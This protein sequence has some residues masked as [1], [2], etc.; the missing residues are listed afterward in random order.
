MRLTTI[1]VYPPPFVNLFVHRQM[2]ELGHYRAINLWG[3]IGTRRIMK[4][5]FPECDI[6]DKTHDLAFSID[7]A[8]RVAAL[9]FNWVFLNFSWGFPP[10]V[11]AQDWELFRTAVR[12][13]HQVGVRVFGY[14]QA[15]NCVYQDSYVD[16]D[17]YA[18]DPNGN[19]IYCYIGR[20]YTSLLNPEWQAEVRGHIRTLVD[21]GADGIFFDNP[22][23]GGVGFDVAEMPL[24]VIGSYD[25]Y[26]QTAYS[27]QFD[28][29][30]I[31]LVLNTRNPAVQQYLRWRTSIAITVLTKWIEVAR[32]LN[33]SIL[34]GANNFDAIARNSYVT[35][36]MDL[37]GF[38][39]LQDVVTVEN[40][41]WPHL[42]D[43]DTVIAGAITI[44]ASQ[45]KSHG[46]PVTTKPYANGVGLE[47][48]WQPREFELAM[49]EAAAMK[50]PVVLQ[51]TGFRHIKQIT[52]LLH[53]RYK[54]QQ[55]TII[56]MNRWL[57]ANRQWLS[58]RRSA[59]PLAIYYPYDAIHW[60]WIDIAPIFFAACETLILNGF[61]L[62]IVG[63]EAW[64]GVHTLIVP[65]GKIDGLDKR[66]RQFV[67]DGGELITLGKSWS[68]V[69]QRVLWEN[70]RP[71][72]SRVPR[73]R[74]FRHRLNQGAAISW[75]AY[76]RYRWARWL[77][78]RLKIREAMVRSPM[79]IVPPQP[80]QKALVDAIGS[81]VRPR[82]VSEAPMLLT[83]WHEPDGTRQWHVV[84]Y[85]DEAQKVTLHLD[86]LTPTWV[87]TPGEEK[88]RQVVG[89]SLVLNVDVAKVIRTAY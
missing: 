82:L 61:P 42:E 57:E 69:P 81:G 39:A 13:Y 1:V 45:S 52:L 36:G 56:M 70:W 67:E 59:S 30:Q 79:Y 10:E 33:P 62:R 49:A 55:E 78:R 16:K 63:D 88:L 50:A 21:T 77:A 75:R 53:N 71:I 2:F 4:L 15:S 66:L 27:R 86:D 24:G 54:A 5:T 65:P 85:A 43:D 83:V 25:E 31:P 34:I 14:I 89:S 11:E 48:V 28:G 73:W 51:G 40:F 60:R 26:S 72:R 80:M 12:H 22:W 20:Y 7:G 76:H 84:N 64:T 8:E 17:W 68:E 23:L 3:G 41:S 47:R 87:Y 38:A 37:P 32:N 58:Q 18:L 46:K 6:D 9:G 35:M 44:G 29:E 74:W 19:K